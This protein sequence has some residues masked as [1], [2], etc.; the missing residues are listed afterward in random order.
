MLAFTL[1]CLAN[2]LAIAHGAKDT[3]KANQANNVVQQ[4]QAH[5]AKAL[6]PAQKAIAQPKAKQVEAP[7]VSTGSDMSGDDGMG[8]SSDDDSMMGNF[9]FFNTFAEQKGQQQT[10]QQAQQ[11]QQT[12][13]QTADAKKPHV[14]ALSRSKE[15]IPNVEA[16]KQVGKQ[17]Q[18]LH[19]KRAAATQQQEHGQLPVDCK[20]LKCPFYNCNGQFSIRRQHPRRPRKHRHRRVFDKK[21][22]TPKTAQQQQQQKQQQQ[23]QQEQKQQE[24][25]QQAQKAAQAAHKQQ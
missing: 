20:C 5:K 16:K 14:V 23:K 17:A 21:G 12:T 2:L 7:V 13:A 18:V 19:A 6:I 4:A 10:A 24:Q 22:N 3:P 25:K 11:A 15:I 1:F 9:P 8:T